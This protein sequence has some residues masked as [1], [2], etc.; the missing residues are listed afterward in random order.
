LIGGGFGS[1]FGFGRADGNGLAIVR[2]GFGG[3]STDGR[4]GLGDADDGV[5]GGGVGGAGGFD[6]VNGGA[7][8]GG[9]EIGLTAVAEGG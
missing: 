8:G 7:G 5:I 6:D 1:D 4:T 9:G 2:T 3:C